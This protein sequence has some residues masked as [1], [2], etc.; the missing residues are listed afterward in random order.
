[1]DMKRYINFLVIVVCALSFTSCNG[2]LNLDNDGHTTMTGVFTDRNSTR[3]YLNSCYN[4]RNGMG[5]D[6]SSLTDESYDS[7]ALN[8]GSSYQNW[9]TTGLTV[10]NYGSCSFDGQP[11]TKFYEGI[12]RC[13]V[14][15]TNMPTAT[16][17]GTDTEKSGWLAQAYVLRAFYYL[18]LFKRYGQIPLI[19]KD[20]GTSYD[21]SKAKKAKV[22]EVVKQIIADCDTALSV[23]NADDGFSWDIQDNQ[24]GIMTRGVAYAI[25]S[26]AILFAV[27]PLFD[28]NTY[29]WADALNITKDALYQCLSH[30]YSLW[31]AVSPNAQNAYASYFLATPN[32]KRMTDKETI[33]AINGELS[34]WSSY[35][36]PSISGASQAGICP[37]QELVDSYEMANGQSPISG[38]SDAEHLQPIINS[39]SGY[40]PNN[41]YLNRDPRFYASIYYN[42][43]LRYLNKPNGTKV[44]TYE[45][46]AEGINKTTITHTQ[47]GYYLRKFNDYRS[48]KSANYDGYNRIFRLAEL[49]MNFAE[50]AYE[51][52]DPDTEVNIGGNM[53]FSALDAVNAIRERAGMPDLPSGMSKTDFETRYRNERKIEFAFEGKRFFD[54]RRWKT[55]DSFRVITGMDITMSGTTATYQRFNFDDRV[56]TTDK[57]LLYPLERSEATKMFNLTGQNWQ[58]TGWQ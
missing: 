21:Y 46:G 32:D 57:Y 39:A 30:D 42:G 44:Q 27:S 33:Y 49:Y 16:A 48:S 36:L 34:I 17:Y 26:E 45:G 6:I 22:G 58:N 2:M 18:E 24:N 47:T 8:S 56:T 12:R 51:A 52:G 50:A 53:S 54:V 41:P 31:T 10:D 15:I 13:N 11:W 38:Y 25:K 4:Y 20:L 43:A 9:Y 29:T 40:D 14:F 3:G 5:L 23:P 37:S 35:G 7:R 1:M 55:L 28:D 19:T